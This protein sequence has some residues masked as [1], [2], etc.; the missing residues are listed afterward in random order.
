MATLTTRPTPWRRLGVALPG[1]GGFYEEPATS[2]AAHAGYDLTPYGGATATPVAVALP[3]IGSAPARTLTAYDL[4]DAEVVELRVSEAVS[5][6]GVTGL[7]IET[8]PAP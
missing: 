8:T 4:G 7:N 1:Q 3:P 6:V 5:P 2:P